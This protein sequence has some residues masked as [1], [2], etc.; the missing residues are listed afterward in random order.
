MENNKEESIYQF[1]HDRYSINNITEDM[2][3]DNISKLEKLSE[4]FIRY[5]KDKVAWYYISLYQKLS[6]DFIIEHKDYVLW[7]AIA[8]G[9]KLSL[10]FIRQNLGFFVSAYPENGDSKYYYLCYNDNNQYSKKELSEIRKFIDQY[11]DL[12]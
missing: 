3:W 4:S 7:S 5:Y 11:R 6:E 10:N 8:A 9:Q 12:I 1:L 2:F